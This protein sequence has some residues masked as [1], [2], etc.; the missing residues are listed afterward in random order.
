MAAVT[1]PEEAVG[2]ATPLAAAT[3]DGFPEVRP[4]DSPEED[5]VDPVVRPE[6]S[7]AE[8]P[9]EAPAVAAEPA[10]PVELGQA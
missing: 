5:P 1:T 7:P 8:D 3:P 2:A 9:E 10:R 4:E 6:D